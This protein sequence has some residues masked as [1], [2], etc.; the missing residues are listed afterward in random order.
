MPRGSWSCPGCLA[1]VIEDEHGDIATR[2]PGAVVIRAIEHLQRAAEDGRLAE[3]AMR[4]SADPHTWFV[5]RVPEVFSVF[6]WRRGL[7]AQLTDTCLVISPE[8]SRTVVT[9]EGIIRTTPVGV[10]ELPDYAV[11]CRRFEGF[12]A[13]PESVT[14]RSGW[15]RLPGWLSDTPPI[16]VVAVNPPTVTLSAVFPSPG[17]PPF[18][19]L[20]I[21]RLVLYADGVIPFHSAG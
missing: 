13:K 2:V 14:P 19:H 3:E 15:V 20:G 8:H 16:P 5:A 6:G 18:E 1:V 9:D 12:P 11:L 7:S 21:E 10:G 4:L 17:R